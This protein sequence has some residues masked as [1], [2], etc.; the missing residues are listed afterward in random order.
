MA[1]HGSP[2]IS[3]GLVLFYLACGWAWFT[4]SSTGLLG[5]L[6]FLPFVFAFGAGYATGSAAFWGVLALSLLVIW[7]L[8]Y[9]VVRAVRKRWSFP[10]LRVR[11]GVT[12][13]G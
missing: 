6:L 9:A 8:T 7:V 12:T 3:I 10:R 5:T 1:K 4:S 11:L 2:I 13:G